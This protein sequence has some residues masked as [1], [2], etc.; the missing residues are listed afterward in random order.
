[1]DG[2]NPLASTVPEFHDFSHPI[3]PLISFGRAS[4]KTRQIVL[5]R[6]LSFML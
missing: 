5:A 2:A 1:M 6:R 3:A 4:H